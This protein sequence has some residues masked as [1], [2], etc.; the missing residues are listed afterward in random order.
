M[1]VLGIVAVATVIAWTLK[2]KQLYKV[3]VH[4]MRARSKV[5]P[6]LCLYTDYFTFEKGKKSAPFL[7]KNFLNQI[8]LIF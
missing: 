4:F 8:R 3:S 6:K 2:V 5:I 7:I 1:N